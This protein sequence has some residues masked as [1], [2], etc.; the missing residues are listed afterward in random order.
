MF[1][2]SHKCFHGNTGAIDYFKQTIDPHL[3]PLLRQLHA[4]PQ[5]S[6]TTA[7]Q[8][9]ALPTP[10]YQLQGSPRGPAPAAQRRPTVL[11][12]LVEQRDILKNKFTLDDGN[13]RGSFTSWS[14]CTEFMSLLGDVEHT[15]YVLARTKT[16]GAVHSRVYRCMFGGH[17]RHVEQEGR[18]PDRVQRTF[19]KEC[20]AHITLR[21]SVSYAL[22]HGLL[23]GDEQGTA[24]NELSSQPAEA[25]LLLDANPVLAQMDLQ[26]ERH[27]PCPDLELKV[28]PE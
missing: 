26:H 2:N 17:C 20:P 10:G 28:H 5:P 6:A 23:S 27:P 14:A 1:S 13:L 19:K 16:M 15:N 8:P 12:S 7:T 4:A 3:L 22:S 24:D 11:P 21:M 25:F 9:L 18:K